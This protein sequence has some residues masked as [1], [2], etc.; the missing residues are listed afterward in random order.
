MSL[1]VAF[2]RQSGERWSQY[3]REKMKG[4]RKKIYI[5]DVYFKI[6]SE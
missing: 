3:F 1:K 4:K 6:K 2:D 5:D